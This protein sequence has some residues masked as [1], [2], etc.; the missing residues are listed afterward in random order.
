MGFASAGYGE[1]DATVRRGLILAPEH[2]ALQRL[3]EE[4]N[5]LSAEAK[6]DLV[7]AGKEKLGLELPSAHTVAS[8]S[9]RGQLR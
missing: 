3:G 1:A 7:R 6:I 4:T 8:A 2:D 9:H 5:R